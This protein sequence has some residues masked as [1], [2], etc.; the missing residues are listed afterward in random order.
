MRRFTLAD[1]KAVF[2]FSACEKT[3]T[4]TGDA[5]KVSSIEDARN[6]IKNVWLSEYEKYGY[7]RYALIHKADN[8][9]IGFSGIKYM[10]EYGCPDIGYRMLPNY[11]GK[12]LG[13]EAVKA[14]LEYANNILGE[15]KIMADVVKENVASSK[16]LLNCGFKH[17]ESY[18]E[19]DTTFFLYEYKK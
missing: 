14:T 13:V 10:P 15:Q 12:G 16:I 4:Y 7:G 6:I 3:S 19:N 2:E 8:K 17:T 5:G 9:V 1:A 18:Q 11:W